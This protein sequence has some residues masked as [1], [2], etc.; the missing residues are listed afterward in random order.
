[1]GDSTAAVLNQVKNFMVNQN[2]LAVPPGGNAN[3][4]DESS[5]EE[6][7]DDDDDDEEEEA[8]RSDD[9]KK[10]GLQ[11][12]GGANKLK[13][14]FEAIAS[15]PERKLSS[16]SRRSSSSSYRS[17]RSNRSS[18]SQPTPTSHKPSLVIPQV[19]NTDHDEELAARGSTSPGRG[20]TMVTMGCNRGV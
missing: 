13:G 10:P 8:T 14:L 12:G 18:R 9:D 1:M 11:I 3:C 7:D 4:Y 2:T 19:I 20:V 17:Q 15:V 6:E 16:T 5:S